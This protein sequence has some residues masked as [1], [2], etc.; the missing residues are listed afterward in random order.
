MGG[1]HRSYMKEI[2]LLARHG[3]TVL[4][5]DH[6]GC[7]ESEGEN[8]GGFAQSLSDLDSLLITLENDEK[9]KDVSISV[10]GHSRG[11][12]STLNISVLHPKTT[13]IVAI[14]GFVSVRKML[15]QVFPGIMKLYIPALYKIEEMSNPE[16]AK[17][18]A[19][20]SLIKS[21]VKAMIIHSEYDNAVSYKAHF[22]YLK[23]QLFGRPN[24]H[25]LAFSDKGHNP[26]F[27]QSA[28]KFKDDF[29]ATLTEKTKNGEFTSEEKRKTFRDSYDWEK[30][31]EQD[32]TLWER[33]FGFLDN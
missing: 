6:T 14:S 15:K 22:S 33:I 32:R 25:F 2:E 11:E 28:V 10:V 23:E 5:Y 3:Y 20:E 27:T 21:N 19:A 4:S 17:Y 1:G 29:F 13:H 16:Y 30:M 24:T 26:N 9:Y 18:D 8:I 12:F 7:M 31:T